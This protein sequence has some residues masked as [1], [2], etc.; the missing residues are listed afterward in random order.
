MIVADVYF[1]SDVVGARPGA[2]GL[3]DRVVSHWRAGCVKVAIYARVSKA[4]RDDLPR[5]IRRT[6]EQP[7]H[8]SDSCSPWSTGGSCGTGRKAAGVLE[9]PEEVITGL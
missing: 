6:V 3:R 9:A 5:L 7:A 1:R 2:Y 8:R 4:D